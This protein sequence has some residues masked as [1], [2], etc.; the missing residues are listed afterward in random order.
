MERLVKQVEL[1]DDHSRSRSTGTCNAIQQFNESAGITDIHLGYL[2]D[3]KF[4]S[5]TGSDGHRLYT[6]GDPR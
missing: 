5:S 1:Y 3:G 4:I 6:E 2:G